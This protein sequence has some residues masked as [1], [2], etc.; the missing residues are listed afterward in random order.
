MRTA[1]IASGL[2]AVTLLA[3]CAGGAAEFTA[4]SSCAEYNQGNVDEDKAAARQAW[5]DKVASRYG[6]FA[7]NTVSN[8]AQ[9]CTQKPDASLD[10]ATGAAVRGAS[11]E[12]SGME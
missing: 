3:G 7:N 9:Y 4:S 11:K 10:E 8:I 6:N 5:D 12:Y 2:V 1:S